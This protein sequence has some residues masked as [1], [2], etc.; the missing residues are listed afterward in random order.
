MAAEITSGTVYAT[1]LGEFW[2][3]TLWLPATADDGDFINLD[4]LVG[5][6]L[7]NIVFATGIRNSQLSGSADISPLSWTSGSARLTLGNSGT[8]ANG[9]RFDNGRQAL[10]NYRRDIFFV[11]RGE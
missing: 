1:P 10:S 8:F 7:K 11:A 4:T 6:K 5:A 2:V 9:T 3:G